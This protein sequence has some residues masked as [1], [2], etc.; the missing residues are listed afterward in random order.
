MSHAISLVCSV[1]SIE[2]M[3]CCIDSAQKGLK[4][5]TSK[6]CKL[7]VASPEALSATMSRQ[8]PSS[9]LAVLCFSCSMSATVLARNVHLFTRLW[10]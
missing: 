1:D 2:L 3:R 7:S 5:W 10:V 6:K 9:L 4:T 8:A